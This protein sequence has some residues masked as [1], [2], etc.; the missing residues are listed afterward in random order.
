MGVN[1]SAVV[2]LVDAAQLSDSAITMLGQF[3][4]TQLMN[5]MHLVTVEGD[6]AS[7]TPYV[8]GSHSL[9]QRS[10]VPAHQR[11]D[12]RNTIGARYDMRAGRHVD[13]RRFTAWK[14]RI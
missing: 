3:D 11:V 7:L 4:M 2:G 13:V 5:G 6:E 8:I 9:S 12:P 1:G 10:D 14:W